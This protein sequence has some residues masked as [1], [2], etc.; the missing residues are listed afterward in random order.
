MREE[1]QALVF[2]VLENITIDRTY[3][4]V[5]ITYPMPLF[6]GIK[7]NPPKPTTTSLSYFPDIK[8]T[9]NP[10]FLK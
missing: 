8:K 10:A 1:S 2:F 6:L 9:P 7:K 4:L 3:S 5:W